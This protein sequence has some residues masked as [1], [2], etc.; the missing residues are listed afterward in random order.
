MG[1][2]WR[3]SSMRAV[4]LRFRSSPLRAPRA[5]PVCLTTCAF[6]SGSHRGVMRSRRLWPTCCAR[7]HQ[8][9][10]RTARQQWWSHARTRFRFTSSS[11]LLWRAKASLAACRRKFRSSK[12][13]SV[14]SSCSL[15]VQYMTMLGP[16]KI[17]RMRYA[18]RFRVFPK[19]T[20]STS[21]APYVPTGLPNVMRVWCA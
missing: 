7:Q 6:A 2:R 14:V 20:R 8:G 13:I 16:S 5:L 17:F 9:K 15:L 11:N 1:G 4:N 12:P 19:P 10:L 18:R 3:R 21:I